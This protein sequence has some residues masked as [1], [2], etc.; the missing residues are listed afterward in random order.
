MA[1][2]QK[3]KSAMAALLEYS[4]EGEAN[5]TTQD[6]AQKNETSSVQVFYEDNSD[7]F[8][9]TEQ[10][11]PTLTI[12]KVN[13]EECILWRFADR[14]VDE[15]G[16]ID[17]LAMSLK[18]YGQQEPILVRKNRQNTSH[19]Y[20]VIFGN[21]R[22]RAAQLIN[23]SLDAIYK[24]VSDQQAALFQ[25]EENE[26]RKELSDYARA[27]SYSAQIAGGVFK[28]ET[29]LSEHLGLS[30]QT[31]ND[32]MAYLRVPV[33][34]RELISSYRNLSKKMVSKLATLSKDSA[35]LETLMTLAPK[36]DNKT[37]TTSNI[38]KYIHSYSSDTK[39]LVKKS[40]EKKDKYGNI[41][42][43]IDPQSNGRVVINISK[44]IGQGIN[45]EML[46]ERLVDF[47]SELKNI[48][49]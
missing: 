27:L 33:K 12:I 18:E 20:E 16:D 24:D 48:T 13:P 22:W 31:L 9:P 41:L 40:Y 42:Y 44:S 14:P 5:T 45:L 21:R 39:K 2:K 28:N 25:K 11:I 43:K 35:V 8:K 19:K 23:L 7:V 37:I 46:Q 15:L 30:K 17:A 26:N 32:L 29:D 10:S 34:L 49:E 1:V 47:I 3:P 4:M 6:Q 38:E 36:I